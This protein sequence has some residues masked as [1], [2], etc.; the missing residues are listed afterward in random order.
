MMTKTSTRKTWFDSL[1]K[2]TVDDPSCSLATQQQ[3]RAVIT[4]S[5]S[6]FLQDLP[7]AERCWLLASHDQFVKK[8]KWEKFKDEQNSSLLNKLESLDPVSSFVIVKESSS[9]TRKRIRCLAEEDKDDQTE[10]KKSQ[11]DNLLTLAT[12]TKTNSSSKFSTPT[13]LVY[14]IRRSIY[15]KYV[16]HFQMLYNEHDALAL[17]TLVLHPC[18]DPDMAKATSLWIKVPTPTTDGGIYQRL[19]KVKTITFQGRNDFF[20]DFSHKFNQ[21]PDCVLLYTDVK[22]YKCQN[23]S[24]TTDSSKSTAR[25]IVRSAYQFFFTIPTQGYWPRIPVPASGKAKVASLPEEVMVSSPASFSNADSLESKGQDIKQELIQVAETDMALEPLQDS[26]GKDDMAES[27]LNEKAALKTQ[28]QKQNEMETESSPVVKS[29]SSSCTA[30]DTSVP[31]DPVEDSML[32]LPQPQGV[33]VEISGVNLLYF[34]E[35]DM[36]I[37]NE[38]HICLKHVSDPKITLSDIMRVYS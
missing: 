31:T 10:V 7:L 2:T 19:T 34:D 4:Q 30:A 28:N 3:Q 23:L 22:L 14:T 8:E 13:P 21:M 24:L 18:C 25:T 33:S 32:V 12:T 27:Y 35:R 9:S 15:E 20:H 17:S 5:S 26:V 1:R 16:T 11:Q 29:V 6:S 36:V 37:K 38:S